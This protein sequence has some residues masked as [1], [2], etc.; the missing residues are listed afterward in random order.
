M[1]N[2]PNVSRE[3]DFLLARYDNTIIDAR[4]WGRGQGGSR[5]VWVQHQS[6]LDCALNLV[7]GRHP[8]ACGHYIN[9]PPQGGH[10]ECHD[11]PLHC[12]AA[13]RRVPTCSCLRIRVSVDRKFRHL[14]AWGSGHTC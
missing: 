14:L 4:P 10:S 7:E 8:L 12:A 3:N 2:F 1:V 5:E 6:P 9:H 13:C 11:R